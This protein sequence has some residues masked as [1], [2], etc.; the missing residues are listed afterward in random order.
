MENASK[1]L[2]MAGGVLIALMVIG[3]LVLMFSNLTAYQETNTRSTRSSQIAE[4][5]NQY[6]TYNRDDV[7]GSDLYSVLNKVIDYN[8]RQSTAG[9]E[10]SDTGAEIGYEPMT[11][12]FNFDGKRN[13]FTADGVTRLFTSNTYNVEGTSSSFETVKSTIDSLENTYGQDSLS[14]LTT[15]LSN[16]FVDNPTTDQINNFNSASRKVQLTVND[17]SKLKKNSTIYTDVYKYYEYV[18]FK[19]AYFDCESV[20]Y[21]EQTG[22]IISMTYKFNGDFN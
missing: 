11:V 6:E 1:A 19:R 10:G 21:N 16:I 20:E 3:A 7:R 14:R 4:F 22:R 9:T 8:R 5:N 12:S 18:Q 17:T 2:I 15:N 13:E